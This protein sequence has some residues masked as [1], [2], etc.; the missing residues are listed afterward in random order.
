MDRYELIRDNIQ[1][2]FLGCSAKARKTARSLFLK[3]GIVSYICDTKK[4]SP[5]SSLFCISSVFVRLPSD[6]NFDVLCDSLFRLAESDGSCIWILSSAKE[7]Y[8][9]FIEEKRELLESVFII[10]DPDGIPCSHPLLMAAQTEKT[11]EIKNEAL[12]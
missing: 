5:F 3:Y 11:K 12:I 7:D 6:T 9:D 4:P 1:P 8:N 2:V 10:S